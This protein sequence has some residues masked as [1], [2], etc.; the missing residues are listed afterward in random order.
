MVHRVCRRVLDHAQDAED[1]F[2]A[3]FLV[4]VRKARSIARRASLASWLYGV[5]Y[6]ISLKARAAAARR[7][8]REREAAAMMSPEPISAVDHHE[9]RAVLDQELSRLP[10][11]CRAPLILCYLEGKTQKEA[12]RVLGCPA[13]SMTWRLNQARERLRERLARRGVTLTARG[14]TVGLDKASAAF[15]GTLLS[16]TTEAALL[17]LAGK[18][19]PAGLISK[20]ALA[21]AK[22]AGAARPLLVVALLFGLVALRAGAVAL[23]HP[24][25]GHGQ[26]TVLKV[27][28]PK[29]AS[30]AGWRECASFT[31]AHDS[32]RLLAL[33]PQGGARLVTQ[34]MGDAEDILRDNDKYLLDCA[35]AVRDPLTGRRQ[36]ALTESSTPASVT[37][38]AFSPDGT[39][40]ASAELG[41]VVWD[42]ATG[43]VRSRFPEDGPVALIV[44][45]P[46]GST[47]AYARDDGLVRLCNLV[48]G[49]RR[50][51]D[52]AVTALG[53]L[54]FSAGGKSLVTVSRAGSLQVW[55]LPAGILQ[56]TRELPVRDTRMLLSPDA[57]TLLTAPDRLDDPAFRLW[58][59]A[60]AKRPEALR[61]HKRGAWIS[62]AAFSGDGRT[63]LV[64]TV[65]GS[66]TVFDVASQKEL[67]RLQD[68]S[69]RITTLALDRTGQ[70]LAA[71]DDEGNVKV[72]KAQPEPPGPRD[73]RE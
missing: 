58:D 34:G 60:A 31:A 36:K 73:H 46:D 44:F 20:S 6:R 9:L 25:P 40:L 33:S 50:A 57:R 32:V 23:F 1:A 59:L 14:L 71:G 37:A 19:V 52:K 53:H 7:R 66:V 51:L 30:A 70:A 10:E 38:I 8:A 65:D 64:G 42:V 2:Q 48:S 55:D 11:K 62:A 5:A 67:A 72:W 56:A 68:L 24:G 43:K 63:L 17:V 29:D 3:T 54:A 47:L 4:L 41:A 35:L 12:A 28:V 22:T 39:A 18:A 61:P 26:R 27:S 13:G 15:A 45:S 49:E 69:G 21:L 16:R